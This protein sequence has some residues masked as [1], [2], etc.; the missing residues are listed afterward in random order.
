MQLRVFFA[1]SLRLLHRIL[2][3]IQPNLL[4]NLLQQVD[5]VFLT[6][7]GEEDEDISKLFFYFLEFF[8]REIAGLLGRLPEEVFF[9]PL[10]DKEA[11]WFSRSRRPCV[12]CLNMNTV[13]TSNGAG[14]LPR[15][16]LP[17]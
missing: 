16:N 2:R 3:F 7:I 6:E 9:T 10:E 11:S 8:R 17:R 4:F 5:L 1:R 13:G 12:I 15:F 14:Q